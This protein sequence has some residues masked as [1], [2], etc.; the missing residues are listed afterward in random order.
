M[1]KPV[2][3][4]GVAATIQVQLLANIATATPIDMSRSDAVG[5]TIATGTSLGTIT[6]YAS[7]TESGTY[8]IF[9]ASDTGVD[10]TFTA[11]A[12]RTMLLPTAVQGW[13]RFLKLIC[14]GTATTVT[15]EGKRAARF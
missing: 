7:S 14:S 11:T 8:T 15:A 2:N 12:A 13:P 1:A 10:V 5:L 9:Q 3:V 6:V 4:S